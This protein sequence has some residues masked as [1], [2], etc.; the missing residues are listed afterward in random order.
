M[1][2]LD[3]NIGSPEGL[4]TETIQQLPEELQEMI[5]LEQLNRQRVIDSL[6]EAV[7]EA[8]NESIK[9]RAASG[10]ETEW[11]EDEEYYAGVDD[12]N[13]GMNRMVKP[14]HPTGVLSTVGT[15]KKTGKR[16]TIFYNVTRQY[17]DSAAA[18]V[19]EMGN[20]TDDR[21]FKLKSLPAPEVGKHLDNN[22][23]VPDARNEQGQP[24]QAS[25]AD[26]AQQEVDKSQKKA[27]A[28]EKRIDSWLIPC[29]WHADQRKA[30]LDA[31]KIGSGVMKGPFPSERTYKRAKADAAGKMQMV[32]EKEMVPASKRIS[33]WNIYPSSD[34]GDNIQKGSY[35][36]ELDHVNAREL[37][38]MKSL[39]GYI[40]TQIDRAIV[41]G[42]KNLSANNS[43]RKSGDD[44]DKAET[45]YDIWYYYGHLTKEQIAA[46]GVS[47]S[48][49]GE[50]AADKRA[51]QRIAEMEA[52][53]CIVTMV[54]DIAIKASL[55]PLDSGE[56]PYDILTWERREGS[57]W[58]VGVSRIMRD[59]QRVVNAGIRNMMDNAGLSGGVQVGVKKGSIK[60]MNGD[61]QLKNVTF[62]ELT[63]D[64]AK[65]INDCLSFH[66]IPSLQEELMRII[67]FGQK[68]AE[69][70]TG[71]PLLLQGQTGDAPDTVGGMQLL[72][73]NATATRRMIARKVD[74]ELT[75][76]HIRRYYEWLLMYGEDEAEKGD[77]TIDARGSQSL[78][79]RD[80]A[81]SFAI[82]MVEHA[83]EPQFGINPYKAMQATLRAEMI[84]PGTWQD[85]EETYKSNMK[86]L[87]Q[88]AN[89]TVQ[90]AQI[91]TQSAEKIAVAELA[92]EQKV[93]TIRSEGAVQSTQ[94]RTQRDA[95][96]EQQ[97]A[98]KNAAD[99]AFQYHEL[100]I[101]REI[102]LLDYA[103]KN[104]MNLDNVK[105]QLANNA[106]RLN[107]EKELA[108][109]AVQLEQNNAST[110]SI[111]SASE[112][113]AAQVHEAGMHQAVLNHQKAQEE[114][115]RK[116]AE[117]LQ[118]MQHKHEINVANLKPAVQL[119]WKAGKG[120]ALN[121]MPSGKKTAPGS[122]KNRGA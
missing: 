76:P 58:G 17:V 119:P 2:L 69:D 66:Q 34:C 22:T 37:R 122:S 90:A 84:D 15:G 51:M 35:V 14:N 12:A 45:Q 87:Q 50:N 32:I 112:R 118:A 64:D 62:W 38:A 100:Q 115:K 23:P 86:N 65:S 74:S 120:N 92:N 93:A 96:Y 5:I 30:V 79:E 91:R 39:D 10:I 106:M 1:S 104:N 7:K 81:R 47:D 110:D 43:S 108:A 57:P 89:P 85:D 21:N 24:V 101:K 111:S 82:Q 60:P 109:Q 121:Q 59:A 42:P 4:S 19:S 25:V 83:K 102:A 94:I 54:N 95:A 48:L 20:P 3:G 16:S 36:L 46:M 67:Q 117:E 68:M 55:N 6:S 97:I 56:Y 99:N 13:R 103:N 70:V 11:A 78:V 63:D 28:A 53:P 31:A 33:C 75:E 105:A 52:C 44:T 107:T 113:D 61:W 71:M 49:D 73:K 98:T 116:H 88:A 114:L 29:Q 72:N 41:E 18:S 26:F 40:A 27:D 9:Y 80:I 8:R 77:F